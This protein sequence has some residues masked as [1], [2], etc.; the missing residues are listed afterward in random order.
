M[1]RENKAEYEGPGV[2]R[3][4]KGLQ[5][6]FGGQVRL[7]TRAAEA[8]RKLGSVPREDLSKADSVSWVGRMPG[9]LKKS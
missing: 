7:H 6:K 4:G 2:L 1:S 9:L 5:Y 3:A 8:W